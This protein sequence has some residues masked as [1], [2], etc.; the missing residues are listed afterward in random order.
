MADTDIKDIKYK[1][2]FFND[3]DTRKFII[4]KLEV[5]QNCYTHD[6]KKYLE[7]CAVPF[8]S[9]DLKIINRN[10]NEVILKCYLE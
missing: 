9:E 5:L 2:S 1:P 4:M 6:N 3:E 7:N 8:K 10:E